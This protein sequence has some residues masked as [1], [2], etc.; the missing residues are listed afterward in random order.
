MLTAP[1]VKIFSF[2]KILKRGLGSLGSW[3]PLWWEYG[4]AQNDHFKSDNFKYISLK[5]VIKYVV[6][7]SDIRGL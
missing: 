7:Y 5:R 1:T 4:A 3:R 2:K 6:F